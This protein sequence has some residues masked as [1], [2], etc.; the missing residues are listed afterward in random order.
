MEKKVKVLVLRNLPSGG[1]DKQDKQRS[2]CELGLDGEGLSALG[3]Q[4][5]ESLTGR[6]LWEG[7]SGPCSP[8]AGGLGGGEEAGVHT[9]GQVHC[10]VRQSN[11]PGILMAVDSPVL[12]YKVTFPGLMLSPGSFFLIPLQFSVHS[13]HAAQ[14]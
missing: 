3:A 13:I 1:R 11:C 8:G 4:I 2:N 14:T 10:C 12:S 5:R 6:L 9:P 7:D